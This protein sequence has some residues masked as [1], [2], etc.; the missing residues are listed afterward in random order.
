MR[1]FRAKYKD[2]D[3]SK[4]IAKKWYVEFRD[5]AE[6]VRRLHAFEDKRQSEALGRNIQA[7]VNCKMSGLDPDVKLNQWIE[8]LPNSLM[9][10]FVSWGLVEG[11][12]AEIV[13]PLK[14]H[15]AEYQK[16]LEAKG[17]SH[18][19]VVRM[20]NRLTKIVKDCRFTYFRDITQSAVELYLGKLKKEDFTDTSRGHYL[21]ALK[22]FL[23]WARQDRRIINN[24]I[25][26][27]EKP[28]RD[29]VK[30][31]I[32]TPE[33]F[34]NLIKTTF[35]KNILIKD[36]TGK[37][38]TGQERAALY[39]LAGTT[40]LRRNELL[41]LVWDDIYLGD[42]AFVRVRASIAKNGKEAKQPIA[43]IAIGLLT[44]LKA[45]IKPADTD[46]VFVSF[47]RGINTAGLIRQDLKTAEIALTD[48]DGNEIVFHSLRNSFISFLANS[49]TP[50]KVVQQLARHSDPRLTFNVYARTFEKSEQKALSCLPNFGGFVLASCLAFGREKDA[51]TD[52]T[53]EHKNA[54]QNEKPLKMQLYGQP[55]IPP[56]GVEPL[57][58][59]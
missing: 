42:G 20:H 48:K 23:N 55:T 30:K 16:I 50:A 32:L 45:Y 18:D 40:G 37:T 26:L 34:I 6:F 15:I 29:S 58:H 53:G 10:K 31:G 44:V 54:K 24:P 3:G 51:T 47:D 22:T 59:G 49:A 39:L 5:H 25:A 17:Y 8:S 57:S 52:Y 41:N 43:A 12:R 33:Q 38:T 36:R 7:L 46:R 9:K 27:M 21:D 13:K 11:Q 2:R 28:A 1:V 19:Y 14:E 56:R 4:Q 35:E